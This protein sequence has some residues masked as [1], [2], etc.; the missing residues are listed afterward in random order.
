MTDTRFGLARS[1]RSAQP[2]S[3]E[4]GAVL[5]SL[6]F[7]YETYGQLNAARSNAILICHATTGDQYVASAHP[8]TGKPGWWHNMIGAGLPVD[9]E[10]FCVI[11]INI[12]GSCMGSTG[13]SSIKPAT[14]LPYA[15]D[16]PVITIGDMVEAQK[17]LLDHLE[18]PRLHA[19]IGP[20]M[21]GMQALEWAVRNPD[22]VSAL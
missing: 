2:F 10:S 21:G 7:A 20:S 1:F 13:P 22:R 5:A 12:L 8:R 18:I 15:M 4:C 14:G 11:C 19:I 9:T 6:D 16:F 17:L 3:L